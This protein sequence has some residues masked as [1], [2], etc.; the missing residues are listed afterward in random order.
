MGRA[1]NL[2]RLHESGWSPGPSGVLLAWGR[3]SG[4][5]AGAHTPPLQV[6]WPCCADAFGIHL[7]VESLWI[8]WNNLGADTFVEGGCLSARATPPILVIGQS[9]KGRPRGGQRAGKVTQPQVVLRL[10]ARPL[11]V[12]LDP[13]LKRRGETASSHPDSAI[14]QLFHV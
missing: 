13:L 1:R 3:G 12:L 9:R 8:K 10:K 7:S 6:C 5:A 11:C 14:T 2:V 4:R